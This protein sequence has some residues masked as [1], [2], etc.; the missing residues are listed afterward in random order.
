MSENKS[1]LHKIGLNRLNINLIIFDDSGIF[2]YIMIGF[3]PLKS[4]REQIQIMAEHHISVEDLTQEKEIKIIS[5]LTEGVYNR[6][7]KHGFNSPI[8]KN[9]NIGVH[10]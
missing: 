5:D 7:I 6:I 9:D 2:K 10:S 1:L 3:D 4:E 8:L